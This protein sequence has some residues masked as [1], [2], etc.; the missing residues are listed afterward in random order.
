MKN[1]HEGKAVEKKKI[2][3]QFSRI[4]RNENELVN[5]LTNYTNIEAAKVAA[6]RS[7]S[8]SK[9]A[10]FTSKA[11]KVVPGEDKEFYQ[12]SVPDYLRISEFLLNKK[13]IQHSDRIAIL[14]KL[15]GWLTVDSKT[16][17]RGEAWEKKTEDI[18]MR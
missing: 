4:T 8:V 14:C 17:V 1:I 9:S 11:K 15:N 2:K 10:A 13:N 16:L 18:N 5:S 6:K 7:A 12:S 3:E